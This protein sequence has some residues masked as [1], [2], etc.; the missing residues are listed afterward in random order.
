MEMTTSGTDMLDERNTVKCQRVA[1]GNGL[2]RFTT[3]NIRTLGL[4]HEIKLGQVVNEIHRLQ[5]K[6]TLLQE[7]RRP[8][9]GMLDI[10]GYKLYY[11]GQKRRGEYGVGIL[12]TNDV[13]VE[14][15][16][17]VSP[18]M[19]SMQ[20]IV[21]KLRL[22]IVCC[23]GPTMDAKPSTKD[24]FWR[25]MRSHVDSLPRRYKTLIGGDFNSTIGSAASGNY[26]CV[27]NYH[28]EKYSISDD[29]GERLLRFTEER[30]FR[31]ENT[32]HR[33]P[34]GQLETWRSN[35]NTGW[36]RLDYWLTPAFVSKMVV[37]IRL[38]KGNMDGVFDT[39]HAAL[40]MKLRLPAT[41][42]EIRKQPKRKLQQ[43]QRD[44]RCLQQPDTLKRYVS[45]L[46]SKL[47]DPNP[48]MDS[49]EQVCEKIVTAVH[50]ATTEVCPEISNAADT[51]PWEDNVELQN[52]T[53]QVKMSLAGST[54]RMELL[55]QLRIARKSAMNQ[56]YGDKCEQINQHH[57]EKEVSKEFKAATKMAN[58]MHKKS[59]ISCS[60]TAL[61]E[62]FKEHF[63]SKSD[64]PIPPD[65][66]AAETL[67]F[68]I[69]G[70][71][72]QQD[73][74][75]TA[76]D[77]AEV[78]S[79]LKMMKN[80]RC[81]GAG[82]KLKNEQLKYGRESSNLI[83]WLVILL[84]L[85]WQ[86]VTVPAIWLIS[87]IVA[88]YK[89]GAHSDAANYRPLSI[90]STLSRIL[91]MIL[92]KRLEYVYNAIIDRSQCGF[93]QNSSTA[94]AVWILHE[95]I[96]KSTMK[97]YVLYIDLTAA[98]DK[99]PRH[100]LFYLLY[101]RF[102]CHHLIDLLK[103][104]YT[105]T[106]A[107]IVG[108]KTKIDVKEGCRQ[109]GIEAPLLFNIYF[110]FVA[111]IIDRRLHSALGH[112]YGIL[113]NY[114]IPG[115]C[116]NREQRSKCG[117]TGASVIKKILYADDAAFLFR[118][119]AAMQ[120]GIQIIDSTLTEFG[121]ILSIKK[122]ESQA[123]NAPE[124][125]AKESLVSLNNVPIKNTQMFKYLGVHVDPVDV[126]CM[127]ANRIASA[128]AKFTELKRVLCD[129]RIRMSIRVCFLETFVR[130]RLCYCAHTWNLSVPEINQLQVVW[131]QMIRSM[132]KGGHRRINGP[133]PKKKKETKAMYKKRIDDGE[134]DYAYRFTNDDV[135]SIT[136][137]SKV[138]TFIR[139]QNLRWIGHIARMEN[140][141][142]QK[143]M[144]FAVNEQR[145]ARD[146]W[147]RLETLTG[148][149]KLQLRRMMMNK[150][151]FHHWLDQ[152]ELVAPNG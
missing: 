27:G 1:V 101:K 65:L 141:M 94:D 30:K 13:C 93:R 29:N 97:F 109:G 148:M 23:Y 102:K 25:Q 37:S 129:Q 48:N 43:K 83:A 33:V 110:D 113:F 152:C 63:K 120:T 15:V 36:K 140:Y 149:N 67:D 117:Q 143:Q 138:S 68:V 100:L 24:D 132:V 71:Q 41:Q 26:R 19:M 47:G 127:T 147:S 136:K 118:S 50:S 116:T 46:N 62:H 107:K 87:T 61:T 64:I 90:T 126:T 131:T 92:C 5:Y 121:L 75:E 125:Y 103:A 38:R 114:R 135:F 96:S 14:D 28:L 124:D 59:D 70:Y 7:V 54:E 130:P 98:Y 88:L 133:P 49:V 12:V 108:S 8:G 22:N 99:L 106:T 66:L 18:R 119:V 21:S 112:D 86:L 115:E 55:K 80:G 79:T 16:Q 139:K 91:P 40:E 123:I 4:K 82:D 11:S 9:S 89:K 146:R 57:I 128:W 53:N 151:N 95:C 2:T 52:I 76:P 77:S 78:T 34:Q 69:E 56:Y 85:I 45:V 111:R 60:K 58:G 42:R 44:V 10:N 142:P 39:D 81:V 134:W 73:V 145:Y 3:L 122:T 105:E 17:Y 35:A 6:V 104:I 20:A 150:S 51:K 144:L 72:I 74:N 137:A 32:R 31:I 84:G